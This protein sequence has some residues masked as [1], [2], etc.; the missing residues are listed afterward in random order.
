M[1]SPWKHG[2]LAASHLEGIAS[3]VTFGVDD[4]KVVCE[5]GQFKV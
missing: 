1:L 2:W 5:N 3:R 4:N